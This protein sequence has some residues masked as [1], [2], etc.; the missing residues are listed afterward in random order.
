MIILGYPG[1]ITADGN[2]GTR[3]FCCAAAMVPL[4]YIVC[5]WLVGLA[6]ATQLET[7]PKVRDWSLHSQVVKG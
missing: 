5:E 4:L 3:W 1:E 6:D 7:E 2:L